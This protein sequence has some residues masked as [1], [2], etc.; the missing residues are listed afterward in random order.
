MADDDIID[1]A[2]IKEVYMCLFAFMRMCLSERLRVCK[3]LCKKLCLREAFTYPSE[4]LTKMAAIEIM[5]QQ[6]WN[7]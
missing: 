7:K 4:P 3:K 5:T 2:K 6:T 1:E